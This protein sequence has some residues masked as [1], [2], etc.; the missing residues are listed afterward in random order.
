MG[1]LHVRFLPHVLA[2]GRIM[3]IGCGSGRDA[4]AFRQQGL[5]LSAFDGGPQ[6]ADLASHHAGIDVTVLGFLDLD[7]AT[8]LGLPPA[9][10]FNGIWACASL[11]HISPKPWANLWALL[12]P[13]TAVYS[14]YKQA[15]TGE[16]LDE[17]TD[18]LGRLFT[19]ADVP[20][21]SEWLK[22]LDG[23]GAMT[24]QMS[25]DQGPDKSKHG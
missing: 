3:A 13:G 11:L 23:I 5:Q 1:P 2:G 18:A 20:R 14:S 25:T 12:K 6:L 24:H 17:R 9:T 10:L 4:L 16:P 8:C 7:D 19:D 22:P 21:L 15:T